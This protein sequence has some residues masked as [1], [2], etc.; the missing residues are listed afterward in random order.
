MRIYQSYDEIAKELKRL[1][2]ERQIA[3]QE[4]VS[5]KHDFEELTKPITWVSSLLKMGS[6][7][8]ILLLVKKIFK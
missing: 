1:D 6:K 8:G 2:L 7:Y 4:L 5:V 3:Y